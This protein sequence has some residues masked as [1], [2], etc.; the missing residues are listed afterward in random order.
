[1]SRIVEFE[2]DLKCENCGAQGAYDFPWAAALCDACSNSSNSSDSIL[3]DIDRPEYGSPDYLCDFCG[4]FLIDEM[5]RNV[6]I[7]RYCIND[8]GA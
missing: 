2:E 6:R 3:D 1:M 7:C 8:D 5:D 4:C